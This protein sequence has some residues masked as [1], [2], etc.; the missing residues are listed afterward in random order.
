MLLLE[1]PV[2]VRHRPRGGDVSQGGHD[3]DG[4]EEDEDVVPLEDE[5]GS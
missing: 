5:V 3:T 2:P 1:C 4:L